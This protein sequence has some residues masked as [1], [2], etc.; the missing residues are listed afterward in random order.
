MKINKPTTILRSR[1]W[2]YLYVTINFQRGISF[3]LMF[4]AVSQEV[5]LYIKEN[6]E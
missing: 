3:F 2:N 6:K 5:K 1:K 4:T